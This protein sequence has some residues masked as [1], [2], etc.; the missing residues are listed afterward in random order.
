[1]RLEKKARLKE[2]ERRRELAGHSEAL[3]LASEFIRA[4]KGR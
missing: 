1:M 2:R 3:M 4:L